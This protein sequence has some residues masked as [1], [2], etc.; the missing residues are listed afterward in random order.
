[1]PIWFVLDGEDIVFNTGADTVKGRNLRRTGQASLCV[2]DERPP[3]SFVTIS[4]PV[5]I[6]DDVEAMLPLSIRIGARYM[7][8]DQGSSSAGATPSRARLL[9]RAARPSTWS[10]SARSPTDRAP[11]PRRSAAPHLGGHLD[12]HLELGPLL[13]DREL[14]ALLGGGEAAL[15]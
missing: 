6:S 3:F 13:V 15:R 2:D 7:G 8:A 14:V 5:T 12:D 11:R 1:M 10:R 9:V 4:G